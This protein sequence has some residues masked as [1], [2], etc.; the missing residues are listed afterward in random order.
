MTILLK[1]IWP[2][3]NT[4]DFKIHFARIDNYGSEPLEVW[5]GGKSDK[6]EWLGWQEYASGRNDFN[7]QYIFSLM[8]FYHETDTWLFGGIFEVLERKNDGKDGYKVKLTQI[9]REFIGRLKIT[10]PYKSRTTRTLMEPNYSE[11]EIK[12]ILPEPYS[13]RPFPGF[14][15]IDVPFDELETLIKKDRLD[16][17]TALESIKGIYLLRDTKTNKKYVG[18]A[19][20]AGGI[21]SRWKNYIDTGHGGNV[22]IQKLIKD[23]G[24]TEYS[25]KHFRFALLEPRSFSTTDEKIQAREDYWKEILGT[26]DENELNRN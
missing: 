26:R 11:F 5:V 13:G 18:K 21:W 22:G 15:E 23:S 17:K 6:T 14:E 2:I 16:W 25:K 7:Q 19:D 20:G 10:S 12:E 8:K 4:N 3:N 1:D 24:D 9:G